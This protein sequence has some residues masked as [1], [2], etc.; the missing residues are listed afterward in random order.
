[1]LVGNDLQLMMKPRTYTPEHPACD[2]QFAMGNA[3]HGWPNLTSST[4][5]LGFARLEGVVQDRLRGN[6]KEGRDESEV[7]SLHPTFFAHFGE[8]TGIAGRGNLDVQ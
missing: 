7:Q 8:E 3:Q 2:F 6:A 1:M 4:F 5:R